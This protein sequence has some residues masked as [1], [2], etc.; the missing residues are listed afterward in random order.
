M[1]MAS[2]SVVGRGPQVAPEESAREGGPRRSSLQGRVDGPSG[3]QGLHQLRWE[4][5]EAI[6]EGG[7]TPARDAGRDS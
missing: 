7:A 1:G 5:Q 4:W 6:G 2:R 3:P